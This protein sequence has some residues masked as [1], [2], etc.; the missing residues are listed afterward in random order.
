M[1]ASN[2]ETKSLNPEQMLEY[3]PRWKSIYFIWKD[4][5]KATHEFMVCFFALAQTNKYQS[6]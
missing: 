4:F 3:Q 1:L 6:S 2:Y 5:N